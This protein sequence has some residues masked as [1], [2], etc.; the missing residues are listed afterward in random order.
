MEDERMN[1]ILA[2]AEYEAGF[3]GTGPTL[4]DKKPEYPE[5][6]QEERALCLYDDFV[7]TEKVVRWEAFRQACIAVMGEDPET[8]WEY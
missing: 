4:L 7:K 1:E 5:P 8:D 2:W 6:T 3:S